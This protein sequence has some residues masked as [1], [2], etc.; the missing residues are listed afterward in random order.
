MFET[1]EPSI[2]A[3]RSAPIKFRYMRPKVHKVLVDSFTASAILAVHDAANA[4]N[5]AKLQRMIA[6][7]FDQFQRI[8]AFAFKVTSTR[9]A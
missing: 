4:E 2:E 3:L 1:R 5:Q 6:G 7:T 9:K 8:A